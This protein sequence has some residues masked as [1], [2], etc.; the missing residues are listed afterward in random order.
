MFQEKTVRGG[1]KMLDKRRSYS[2]GKNFA[3]IRRENWE[4]E[5]IRAATTGDYSL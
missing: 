4:G 2:Q 1:E 5:G 3:R